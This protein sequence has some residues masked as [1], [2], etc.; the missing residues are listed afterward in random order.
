MAFQVLDRDEDGLISR[1]AAAHV[2]VYWQ[3]Q[4]GCAADAVPAVLLGL[5]ALQ[6]S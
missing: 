2:R 5:S 6:P 1:W 4:H 3:A